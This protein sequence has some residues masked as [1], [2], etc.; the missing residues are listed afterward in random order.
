MSYV[1]GHHLSSGSIQIGLEPEHGTVILN[2]CV[3]GIGLVQ[4]LYYRSIGGSKILDINT[5]FVARAR[6]QIDKKVIAIFTDA[7]AYKPVFLIRPLIH[8]LI[9]RLGRADLVEIEFL[10]IVG[11]LHHV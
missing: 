1:D 9:F 7:T 6:T 11:A 4:Q 8:K 3:V 2:E 10:K 5:V